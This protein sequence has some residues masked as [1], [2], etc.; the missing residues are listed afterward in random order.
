MEVVRIG[1]LLGENK[2]E[3]DEAD[4]IDISLTLLDYFSRRF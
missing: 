2:Q 3:R 1:I 4:T